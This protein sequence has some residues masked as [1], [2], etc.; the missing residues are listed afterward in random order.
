ML[1]ENPNITSQEWIN[2]F[3]NL[4]NIKGGEKVTQSTLTIALISLI[5]NLRMVP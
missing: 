1:T 5:N 3:N 2:Y 4:F